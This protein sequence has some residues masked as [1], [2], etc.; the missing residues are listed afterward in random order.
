M[1]YFEISKL[2]IKISTMTR[3]EKT[4]YV[5]SVTSVIILIKNIIRI[6]FI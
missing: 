3:N 2:N 1:S 4:H 5:K 6:I